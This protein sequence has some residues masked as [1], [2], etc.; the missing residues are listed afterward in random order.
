MTNNARLDDG[1]EVRRGEA[2]GSRMD[3]KTRDDGG[4]GRAQYLSGDGDDA[5]LWTSEQQE[6]A[7]N[8]MVAGRAAAVLL[9]Q[10]GSWELAWVHTYNSRASPSLCPSLTEA[11]MAPCRLQIR[12]ATPLP[13]CL[14]ATSCLLCCHS[15]L[16]S[17]LRTAAGYR[18]KHLLHN[19]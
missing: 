10:P 13:R 11:P 3:E 7:V 15:V 14:S 8:T 17:T 18:R 5:M 16:I 6:E 2:E 9:L 1:F 12:I 19:N 4:E